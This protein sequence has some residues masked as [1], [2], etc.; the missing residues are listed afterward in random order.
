MRTRV[1]GRDL[2]VSAVGYGC[3]GLSHAYGP[4]IPEDEAVRIIRRAVELGYTLFDTAECYTGTFADGTESNNERIVGEALAP[5]RDQVVIA[6][7]FGVAHHGTTL[8]VDSSPETIR[9]SVD[10][11]LRRLGVETIDLYYQHRIDPRVEPE[12]V[13]GVMGELIAAGKI[14]HWGISETDETYL[15]RAHAVCPVTAIQ[16]RYSMMARWHEPLFDVCDE[17]G[18]GFVAFSPMANGFLST[19]FHAGQRFADGDFRNTMP[20]YAA[21]SDERNRALLALL[22]DLAAAHDATPAQLS[23]AWMIDKRPWI[24]PIPGTR[25][26]TRLAENAGAADLCLS[27]DEVAS[28]DAVLDGVDM[29]AV[30]GGHAVH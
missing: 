29:S 25:N 15:R 30:F 10:G 23:M 2:T 12:T 18:V 5:V 27:P 7:K 26:E 17:L 28:I 6:T 14:R 8:T 3:M 11:S 9:R 16:N 20:Q 1:L 22:R 4:A 24:V 13:A 21:G 19:A